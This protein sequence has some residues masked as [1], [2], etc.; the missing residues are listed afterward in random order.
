M[1]LTPFVVIWSVM[2]AA[3]L[4]L[5]ITRNVAGLHEDDNL[6]LVESEQALIPKQ[7]AFHGFVNRIEK[8]GIGLTIATVVTGVALGAIYLYQLAEAYNRLS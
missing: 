2:A 3:V 6:H 4:G 8:W 7:I 1:T 5:A